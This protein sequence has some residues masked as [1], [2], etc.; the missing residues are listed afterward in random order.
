MPNRK[1][2]LLQK[3]K[4]KCP[5]CG[6]NFCDWDVIEEDHITPLALGGRDEYKNLQLLH[7]R[8][9]EKTYLDLIAISQKNHSKSFE[10][11]S[12]FWDK[13]EWEWVD[14]IASFISLKVWKS[15]SDK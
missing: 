9:E 4:G 5:W 2:S 12:Q 13:Y 8:H 6:Q 1:A 3:Q 11:L 15:E 14:D 10:R 7:R